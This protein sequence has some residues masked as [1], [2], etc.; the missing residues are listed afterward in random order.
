MLTTQESQPRMDKKNLRISYVFCLETR[1][2][3]SDQLKAGATGEKR[4]QAANRIAGNSLPTVLT[5]TVNVIGMHK[6]IS[7][8]CHQFCHVSKHCRQHPTSP[9]LSRER[10]QLWRVALKNKRHCQCLQ[11]QRTAVYKEVRTSLPRSNSQIT[12][13]IRSF[14]PDFVNITARQDV[15]GQVRY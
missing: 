6:F 3:G 9:C 13:V 8:N 7:Q 11:L 15:Q 14:S 12:R 10:C 2:E 4:Q 1:C 5:C